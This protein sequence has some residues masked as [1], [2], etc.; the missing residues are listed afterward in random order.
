MSADNKMYNMST[1]VWGRCRGFISTDGV[2]RR[3]VNDQTPN[4]NLQYSCE[5]ENINSGAV[6]TPPPI[7]DD[8]RVQIIELIE[9]LCSQICDSIL[10]RLLA[11]CS[12]HVVH[13]TGPSTV[14][15]K[16]ASTTRLIQA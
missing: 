13:Q 12:P 1:P 10:N 11:E 16:L 8:S 9:D 6:F 2:V 7:I 15:S 3:K 5:G 14:K 4:V